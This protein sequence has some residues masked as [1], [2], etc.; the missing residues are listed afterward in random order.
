M[1]KVFINKLEKKKE[2]K[3]NKKLQ[4]SHTKHKAQY[5]DGVLNISKNFMKNIQKK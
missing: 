1:T 5:K 3:R 4:I 2:E